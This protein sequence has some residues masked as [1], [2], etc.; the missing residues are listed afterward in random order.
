[1]AMY[2]IYIKDVA[3]IV[4]DRRKRL[5]LVKYETNVLT[6]SSISKILKIYSQIVGNLKVIFVNDLRY[7]SV[8]N[9]DI[10]EFIIK[11]VTKL[12]IVAM[13][14]V[15]N[16]AMQRNF[17]SI[18]MNINSLFGQKTN[19]KVLSSLEEALNWSSKWNSNLIKQEL[20]QYYIEQ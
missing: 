12:N 16:N 18:F 14:F 1:M 3:N 4:F 19:F 17:L 10:R 20:G 8:F 11:E 13:I 5:F 7:V 2:N 15:I 6:K 9:K